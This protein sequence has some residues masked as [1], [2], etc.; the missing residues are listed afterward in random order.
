MRKIL[1]PSL[2]ILTAGL[3]CSTTPK[4][5]SVESMRPTTQ[6]TAEVGGSKY[7]ML[8]FDKGISRLSDSNQQSLASLV[9][10]A[11]EDNRKI[12]EVK[13]LAWA[14]REYPND[15]T[16]ASQQEITLAENRAKAIQDYLKNNV[17]GSLDVENHNMA[18]RPNAMSELFK[19]EDFAVK[20]AFEQTSAAPTRSD[21]STAL[22]GSKASKAVIYLTYK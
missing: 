9:Q 18:K 7:I 5:A 1:I 14:D 13:V 12:D 8:S 21:S 2:F 10:A 11:R 20:T 4:E 19:T 22:L 16:K 17:E 15:K 6:A 3:G